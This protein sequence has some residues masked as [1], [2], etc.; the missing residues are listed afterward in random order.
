MQQFGIPQTVD[1]HMSCRQLSRS[2]RLLQFGVVAGLIGHVAVIEHGKRIQFHH[3]TGSV[4][5]VRVFGKGGRPGVPG[6][7]FRVSG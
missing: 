3:M 1:E 4:R 2:E 6:P 7:A 5:D